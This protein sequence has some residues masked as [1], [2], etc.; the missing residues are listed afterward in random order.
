M[1]VTTLLK[2][3]KTSNILEASIDKNEYAYSYIAIHKIIKNKKSLVSLKSVCFEF[4]QIIILLKI[5]L[6]IYYHYDNDNNGH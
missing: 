5:H 1:L 4:L 3:K 2:F 6:R